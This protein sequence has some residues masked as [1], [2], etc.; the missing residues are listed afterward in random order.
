MNTVD[1]QAPYGDKPTER[2]PLLSDEW[3]E[4]LCKED[5]PDSS[6]RWDDPALGCWEDGAMTVRRWY[7]S[8]ITSGELRVAKKVQRKHPRPSRGRQNA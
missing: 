3:M 4:I 8:K 5:Y 2:E 6:E 7:E 1:P